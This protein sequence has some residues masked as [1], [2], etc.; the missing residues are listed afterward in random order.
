MRGSQIKK[1]MRRLSLLLSQLSQFPHDLIRQISMQMSRIQVLLEDETPIKVLVVVH[2]YWPQQFLFIVDYLNK[3]SIPLSIVVTIPKGP[4]E[5]EIEDLLDSISKHHEVNFMKVANVGRDVGPFLKAIETLLNVNWDLVI[6][7]HTKASQKV[8]FESLVRSL[9]R[10]DGR[11]RN[12]IRLSKKFP[13]GLIVHPYFRYPGHKHELNEPA[14][15]RLR[16]VLLSKCYPVPDKW[17]F[18]AGSMYSTTPAKLIDFMQVM[19]ILGLDEFEEENDY[20]QASCAH[21][22]ERLVGL[23]ELDSRQGL[24]CTSIYDYLDLKSLLVKIT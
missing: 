8:W 16:E 6:K 21:V 4:H 20:S 19:E 13:G 5:N 2:A 15:R 22:L 14:M 9:L 18:A 7:L 12:Q 11:I 10:S 1:V 23:H 24:I 3:I 17:F